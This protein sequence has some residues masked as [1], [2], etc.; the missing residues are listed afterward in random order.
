VR[1]PRCGDSV[2]QPEAVQQPA[3]QGPRRSRFL[4]EADHVDRAVGRTSGLDA[5]G[6]LLRPARSNG[7]GLERLSF[8]MGD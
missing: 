7:H 8:R 2:K 4:N 6:E 1:T 5:F 3:H